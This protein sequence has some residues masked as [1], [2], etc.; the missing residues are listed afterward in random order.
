MSQRDRA[1]DDVQ[2]IAGDRHLAED[3]KHLRREG[4]VQLHEVEIIDSQIDPE[5]TS[6]HHTQ[7]NVRGREVRG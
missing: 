7:G 5:A 4:L 2:A 1:A 6:A 3:R